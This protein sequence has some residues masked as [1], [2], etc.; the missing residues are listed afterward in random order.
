L[1][2]TDNALVILH[3]RKVVVAGVIN[4]NSHSVYK[5]VYIHEFK[6]NCFNFS[7]GLC[8]GKTSICV[9][10]VDGALFFVRQ[11]QQI[12]QIQLPNYL[13]PGPLVHLVSRESIVIT[14]TNLELECYKYESMQAFTDNKVD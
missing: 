5:E 10:S 12:F 8:A 4:Q 7:V 2:S 6:R 14:N 3:P 11:E 1:Q 9:Q 13:I